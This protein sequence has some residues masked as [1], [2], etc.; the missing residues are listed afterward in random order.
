METEFKYVGSGAGEFSLKEAGAVAAGSRCLR[1]F[2]AGA[3]AILGVVVLWLLLPGSTA[4]LQQ[5]TETTT[6]TTLVSVVETYFLHGEDLASVVTAAIADQVEEPYHRFEVVL[7]HSDGERFGFRLTAEFNSLFV[8][9][10][11]THG[12]VPAWNRNHK[13]AFVRSGDR[14]VDV[15][16]VHG[17][18]S[19]MLD[20]CD[21]L[22]LLKLTVLRVADGPLQKPRPMEFYRVM[23]DRTKGASFG[24]YC[25]LDESSLLIKSIA[26]GL[27]GAWN[28]EN[29]DTSVHPGDR[30]VAVNSVRGHG[31]ELLAECNKLEILE[32]KLLRGQGSYETRVVEE[33]VA[34]AP[35]GVAWR[36]QT[37]TRTT[38]SSLT[39]T[40]TSVSRPIETSTIADART[41]TSTST[42]TVI[43][44]TTRTRTVTTTESTTTTTVTAA[45]RF[46]RGLKAEFFYNIN[47]GLHLEPVT[48][49]KLKH[50]LS[51]EPDL[52]RI[53]PQ[54][55]YPLT[56]YGW[57]G[58]GVK[59]NFAAR[60]SGQLLIAKSGRY[61]FELKSDDGSTLSL[62]GAPVIGAHGHPDY[63]QHV[64][65][66]EPIHWRHLDPGEHDIEIT[67]FNT[68]LHA[69]LIALYKGPDTE[70][71]LVTIPAYALQ[72]NTSSLPGQ[73]LQDA[74]YLR[75]FTSS[76]RPWFNMAPVKVLQIL[77]LGFVI[78]G[79]LM[80]SAWSAT[81]NWKYWRSKWRHRRYSDLRRILEDERPAVRS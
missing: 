17:S 41:R 55:Y 45:V 70:N 13:R 1:A 61:T 73:L 22:S 48:K 66:A 14:I 58:I 43:V 35:W 62:D 23:L 65:Q 75:K 38:T 46:V 60:W 33:G 29:P 30:I 2:G 51:R 8:D 32:I 25:A 69:G 57:P 7:D 72:S 42:S 59:E 39:S 64:W 24:A 52:V 78:G 12:L 40:T 74:V 16:G 4:R 26:G 53:D 31:R 81:K 56:L 10:V 3:L 5:K 21:K 71:R 27:F 50:I 76:R 37:R 9:K 77:F 18:S 54:V 11:D 49:H 67:Y 68:V 20:E 34:G 63:D 15:N 19:R 44:T 80:G 79:L 36:E 47:H 6:T 28:E